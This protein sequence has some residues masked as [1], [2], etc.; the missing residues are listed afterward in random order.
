MDFAFLHGGGQG[1]W[2]WS[3]TLD[4]LQRQADGAFGRAIVLD[5]PGCGA[6]RGRKTDDLTLHDVA[7]E[8]IEDI[9]AA[10]MSEVVLVGHSQGGQAMSLMVERRPD[11]FRRLVYVS[12]SIPLP[13]QTV[14][15]ML[16]TS[17]QG[18]DENEV[19]WPFDP[20]TTGSVSDRYPVMFCNDMDPDQAAAF[21]GKLGHDMWP[22]QTYGFSDWRHEHH[23]AVPASFVICLQD[24]ILPARWQEIFAD[25][26]RAERRIR[27]DAGHQAMNTRPHALAEIVRHEAQVKR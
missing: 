16:G 11:L 1:S 18:A 5:A 14:T 21:L 27:V 19:G 10:G 3:E 8:L 24:N 6:K 4:A 22:M 25:R 9:E 20:T 12:C 26:F 17:R 7:R 13:G 15:Q 2:V 23:A